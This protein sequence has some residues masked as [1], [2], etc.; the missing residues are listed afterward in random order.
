M[1]MATARRWLAGACGVVLLASCAPKAYVRPGFLDHPPKR[2]AVL[3]FRITY[4]Y[5]VTEAEGI[6]SSHV[7]GRD[8]L[9]K[10]FYYAFTPLGYD[11]L[12]LPDVDAALAAR[13]GPIEDGGWQRATPQELGAAL[14]ADA[15]IYGELSRLMHFSTP[16]YTETSLTASL[17][18]V[19]AATGEE[20]WRSRSLRVAER[21][22]A[23]MK[24]GQ[25]VDF[26]KDQARSVDPHVKFLR[27]ADVAVRQALKGLSNPPMALDGSSPGHTAAGGVRLAVLPLEPKR[28]QWRKAAE[29]LRGYLTAS[30]QESAFD[31]LE[32]QRVDAALEAL[33]WREGEPL[34]QTLN[35]AEL[36]QALGAD[37]VVRG[38]VTNWGRSYLVVESW[39]KAELQL[40]LL[41]GR[42]GEIVW[43]EKRKQTHQAGI[44]KGPTGF[45]SIATAPITGLKTSNLERIAN[46][47]TR[48][49]TE[50]LNK[51]PAVVAYL[52]ERKAP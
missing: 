21:G 6:P 29:T 36:A 48:E 20:L 16:L 5:D 14:G 34:P 22:G 13:W 4:P 44:L 11:D 23:L 33:G 10:T 17:R 47:L 26:V 52:S 7:I 43:T 42:S 3:P 38:T 35:I 46:H 19:D 15:L 1:R 40:E 30:L 50:D 39:V 51:S 37:A 24:K 45:K 49:L 2:V 12:K 32:I 27:I 9:R 28:A 18:M 25:V 41:D 31:V 8:T